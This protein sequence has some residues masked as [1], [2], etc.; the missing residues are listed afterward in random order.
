MSE[1]SRD[2]DKPE[3]REP[4]KASELFDSSVFGSGLEAEHER[5]SVNNFDLSDRFNLLLASKFPIPAEDLPPEYNDA[6]ADLSYILGYAK[7]AF[8]SDDSP[9]DITLTQTRPYYGTGQSIVTSTEVTAVDPKTWAINYL[10]PCLAP[11]ISP[12]LVKL[13]GEDKEAKTYAEVE[14]G[15]FVPETFDSNPSKRNEVKVLQ[16]FLPD[17]DGD[18]HEV[19]VQFETDAF[20]DAIDHA[21]NYSKHRGV[22]YSVIF[23]MLDYELYKK[24]ASLLRQYYL[25]EGSGELNDN[26]LALYVSQMRLNHLGTVLELRRGSV[27]KI[28]EDGQTLTKRSD[29]YNNQHIIEVITHI[30]NQMHSILERGSERTT[31]TIPFILTLNKLGCVVL[32]EAQSATLDLGPCD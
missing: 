5:G 7:T 1:F 29:A 30:P 20:S 2:K 25:D 24:F 17:A 27:A 23:N 6:N 14:L 28:V 32:R 26:E 18:I 13:E 11:F 12:E 31:I 16:K 21:L 15:K 10:V 22:A 19:F 4:A 8:D 3:E 9:P